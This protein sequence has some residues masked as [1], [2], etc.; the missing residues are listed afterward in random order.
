LELVRIRLSLD[1]KTIGAHAV[2][3]FIHYDRGTT[4]DRHANNLQTLSHMV[5]ISQIQVTEEST[6]IQI[7]LKVARFFLNV[8]R[9][10]ITSIYDTNNVKAV[11]IHPPTVVG[12]ILPLNIPAQMVCAA[13]IQSLDVHAVRCTE[14][15]DR[16]YGA[17]T[18]IVHA[19]YNILFL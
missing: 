2:C 6:L 16:V 1:G 19:C 9:Y 7:P 10:R 13:I 15:L 5:A 12:H 17:P 18:L 3:H 8:V 14:L 11:T 4:S